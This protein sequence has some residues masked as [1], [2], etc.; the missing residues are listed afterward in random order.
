[1]KPNNPFHICLTVLIIAVGASGAALA[2]TGNTAFGTSAL[3]SNTTGSNNSAFGEGALASNTTGNNNT[4]SG[5][6]ALLFN[7]AGANNTASGYQ[8][9]LSNTNGNDNTAS[10]YQALYSNAVGI[11]NIA[12]GNF[13]LHQSIG[14]NNIAIGYESGYWPTGS[15]NIHIGNPGITNDNNV[16]KIG[17][18][19]VHKF[20]YIAGISGVN[21][22]GGAAV[23]VNKQ[24]QLGVELSSLRY[25]E[26]VHSM[27]TESARLLKLRPVTFRYKQPDENGSKPEQYG[28]IA[29]EVA[30]VMPELVI[31]NNKGQPETVAYQ[32]LAPLLLNELQKEHERMEQMQAEIDSLRRKH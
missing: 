24:G 8:A 11:E 4:A 15:N 2:Q 17:K 6:N 12:V 5:F 1:M 14:N 19:S 25:K 21:V 26:D 27:G 32:T 31:Y 10:G 13:A 30:K 29:E 23:F 20:T 7:I 22:T 18:Q 3:F 9:L 28:L 16:I